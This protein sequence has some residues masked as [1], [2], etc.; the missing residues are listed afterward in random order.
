MTLE[1]LSAAA[2]CPNPWCASDPKMHHC[3]D[4]ATWQGYCAACGVEAP[5]KSTEADAWAAWN[6]RGQLVAGQ[7]DDATVERVARLVNEYRETMDREILHSWAKDVVAAMK[8][9]KL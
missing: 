1:Q 8:G 2:T 5:E 4:Q 7:P 9:P 3:P 6:D